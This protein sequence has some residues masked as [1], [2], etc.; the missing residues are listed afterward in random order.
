MGET[1]IVELLAIG[2]PRRRLHHPAPRLVHGRLARTDR[3]CSIR[4]SATRTSTPTV[5]ACGASTCCSTRSGAPARTRCCSAP[6]AR[7]CTPVSSCTRSACSACRRRSARL[8][9]GENLLRLTRA[10]SAAPA[11]A[12]G[13]RA[14]AVRRAPRPRAAD[15]WQGE[16]FPSADADAERRRRPQARAGPMATSAKHCRFL[17]RGWRRLS[18]PQR[19]EPRQLNSTT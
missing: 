11:R 16:Q 15:P 19:L 12:R 17:H 14:A 5:R 9:L 6:T 18:P 4:S 1:A 2:V 3:D 8:V 13:G 7:G 10:H